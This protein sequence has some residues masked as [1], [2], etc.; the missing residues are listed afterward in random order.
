MKISSDTVVIISL[1][2]ILISTMVVGAFVS[3]RTIEEQGAHLQGAQ[4][5]DQ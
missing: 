2:F 3:N 4:T 1:S 5:T